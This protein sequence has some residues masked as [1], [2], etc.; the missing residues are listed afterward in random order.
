M[1]D[2]L[3]HPYQF[4]FLVVFLLGFYVLIDSRKL[5]RKLIGLNLLQISV[6]LLLVS[7]G[8]VDGAGP[9]LVAQAGPHANPLPH[10]LVLTAIVVGVSLTALALAIVV[11]LH[12]EFDT[13]DIREIERTIAVEERRQRSIGEGQHDGSIGNRSSGGAHTDP[14]DD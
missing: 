4:A 6:F 13:T 14:D 12:S 3:V 9:P 10:A 2:A 1:I 7:V 5:V 11:R 8:Y